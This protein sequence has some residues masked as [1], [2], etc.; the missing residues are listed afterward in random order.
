MEPCI[1]SL[2]VRSPS[3]SLTWWL[4]TTMWTT[5]CVAPFSISHCVT[6][7]KLVG[8]WEGGPP[9]WEAPFCSFFCFFDCEVQPLFWSPSASLFL[10]L[11]LSLCARFHL[12][13][14]S[15]FLEFSFLIPS[16]RRLLQPLRKKRKI[17]LYSCFFLLSS[18]NIKHLE[19]KQLPLLCPFFSCV[20][21]PLVCLSFTLK[22]MHRLM[23]TSYL[24]HFSFFC[25]V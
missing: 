2:S 12:L 7:S 14:S 5:V 22:V 24:S 4:L 11:S 20:S 23:S 13:S 16:S 17:N 3:E 21:L 6:K 15:S 25:W 8:R 9:Q 18:K 19:K 10:S 1:L